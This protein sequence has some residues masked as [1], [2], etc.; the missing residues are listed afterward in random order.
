MR[1]TGGELQVSGLDT[2]EFYILDSAISI[3]RQIGRNAKKAPTV[4]P[5]EKSAGGCIVPKS[6]N[7][8]RGVVEKELPAIGI[9]IKKYQ[10]L[11]T[12]VE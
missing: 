10:F 2:S 12:K 11:Q 9:R 3:D 4:E 1:D 6:P 8:S 5:L 7:P